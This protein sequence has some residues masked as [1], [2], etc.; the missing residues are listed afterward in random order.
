MNE[1]KNTT[2]VWSDAS[3]K[4]LVGRISA[5]SPAGVTMDVDGKVLFIPF[6]SMRLMFQDGDSK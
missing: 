3:K 4:P 5:K 6:T 2:I 1:D